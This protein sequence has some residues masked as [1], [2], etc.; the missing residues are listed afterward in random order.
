MLIEFLQTNPVLY[1]IIV[2]GVI[3]SIV[4]H[5]LAHGYAAVKQ[6]DDTPIHAGHVTIN[7]VVHMGWMS[8]IMVAIVGIGWGAMP[9]NPS[10]FRSRHGDA[11][12]SAA[13]PAMNLLIAFVLL[14]LAGALAVLYRTKGYD[15][16]QFV[17]YCIWIGVLNLVLCAFNLIP[18]PPL[19]GSNILASFHEPYRRWLMEKGHATMGLFIG[20]FIAIS[21]LERTGYGI[22]AGGFWVASS[23][24]N[25]IVSLFAS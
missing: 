3:F 23:Y 1:F 16:A 13:G 7:P 17:N 6:G 21:V 20:L 15:T 10:R 11:I 24:I 14:T 19:D 2:L 8:I 9:V 22:F 12:V 18:I 4:L 25:L 5:E